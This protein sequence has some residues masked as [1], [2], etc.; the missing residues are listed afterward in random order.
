MIAE[1]A[2]LPAWLADQGRE[3]GQTHQP[4]PRATG[5]A[6]LRRVATSMPDRVR[7]TRRLTQAQAQA[8]SDWYEAELQAGAL[9]CTTTV[10][11]AGSGAEAV[12][13]YVTGTPTFDAAPGGGLWTLTVDLLLQD[14]VADAGFAGVG[15]WTLPWP[16]AFPPEDDWEGG[17]GGGVTEPALALLRFDALP[18]V[19]EVSTNA[20]TDELDLQLSTDGAVGGT[21]LDLGV[22]GSTV[23]TVRWKS[24]AA[25]IGMELPTTEFTLEFFVSRANGWDLP[26]IPYAFFQVEIRVV[27]GDEALPTQPNV[28]AQF[29][30]GAESWGTYLSAYVSAWTGTQSSGS[31]NVYE[32]PPPQL[33]AT[34]KH[35]ALV[36]TPTESRIYFDGQLE[37]V[38]QPYNPSLWPT[39]GVPWGEVKV[40]TAGAHG[41]ECP[42]IDELRVSEGALYTGTS[43][44]PPTGPFPPPP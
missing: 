5:E 38:R 3:P 24:K 29:F 14:V 42:I 13:A 34:P 12:T 23:P 25:G 35:V 10:W 27:I 32:D 22:P 15:G 43:F 9:P 17:T 37:A 44:T 21:A 33:T 39:G 8:W 31:V 19:D 36:V 26:A 11:T 16:P 18:L 30:I 41:A 2:G 7:A 40:S 6:R 20:V 4:A 28:Y 1:P